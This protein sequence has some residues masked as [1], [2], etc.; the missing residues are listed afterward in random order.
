M[1]GL[2]AGLAEEPA[3][4]ARDLD[5]AGMRPGELVR[6]A[7]R[8]IRAEERLH[9]DRG[10]AARGPRQPICVREQQRPERRHQLGAVEQG[11]ALLRLERHRL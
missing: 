9:G 1:L 3:Q 5:L 4:L 6:R 8:D 10:H 7:E 2:E 11:E